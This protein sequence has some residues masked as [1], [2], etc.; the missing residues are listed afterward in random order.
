MRPVHI[1]A[2]G[3]V[4]LALGA[5]ALP[6]PDAPDGGLPF[7]RTAAPDITRLVQAVHHDPN[8]RGR[9]ARVFHIPAAQVPLFLQTNFVPGV[10]P[11]T[12]LYTVSLV[13]H[14]GMVFPAWMTLPA[15]TPVFV[16]RREAPMLLRA[17]GDP[18]IPVASPAPPPP[19]SE[20]VIVPTEVQIVPLP[21]TPTP[22]H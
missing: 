4:F 14:R 7:L 13:S 6:R 12:A 19:G 2:L 18:A 3:G 8:A 5:S 17:T 9:Y 1:F 16:S 20:Q 22:S 11:R 21:T 15:G 10:L